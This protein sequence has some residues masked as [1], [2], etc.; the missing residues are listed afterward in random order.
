MMSELI[1]QHAL[2]VP[3]GLTVAFLLAGF[4]LLVLS[5]DLD[6]K[7]RYAVLALAVGVFV[8]LCV[9]FY[10]FTVDDAYISL[11]Y[12]RNLANGYGLVFS[13]DGSRP[14][15]GYTNFLWVLLETPLYLLRLSDSLIL[16]CIKIAGIA[17]GV[18]VILLTYRMTRLF[19]QDNRAGLFA[20][21][22]LAAV[23]QLSFWAIGGLETT[24]YMFWLLA[25]VY[26][27][28]VEERDNRVHILSMLF[29]TLA[30]LTRWEGVLVVLALILWE[31]ATHVWNRHKGDRL[32]GLG[33]LIP[34]IIVF[35][36]IYG[37]YFL[38][39][40]NFYGYLFPNTVYAR[41][42][43]SGVSQIWHRMNEMRPFIVYLL[44]I[45]ALAWFGYFYLAKQPK[46]TSQQKQLLGVV[47]L[48]L[49]ALSFGS[50]REW[51]PGFRYELP[52]V[53][54]LILFFSVAMW[55]IVG[56]QNKGTFVISFQSGI[57]RLG[58]LLCLGI[59]LLYPAIDLHQNTKYTD[60]LDRAHATL[61]KWLREYAPTDASYASWD[62]G[63]VPYYSELPLIIEI[64]PEGI[65]S[66][67]ITH[68]GY[69]VNYFLSLKPSFIVLPPQ[70]DVVTDQSG[71]GFYANGYFR[72][73]YELIFSFALRK[74]YIL[75]V[76]KH[77]DVYISQAALE[78]GRQL[79]DLSWQEA[80][81][82]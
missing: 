62:M 70:P 28:M 41:G 51:M 60:E 5:R 40:Y 38:W 23:P 27:Y 52:W 3:L 10:K 71:F 19:T 81:A 7:R 73:N 65:L 31:A 2:V 9:S 18:G 15:E 63:A 48:V 33:K 6:R 30:A 1:Q 58:L 26:F 11:R 37:A 16:H 42:G 47:F 80:Q 17:F 64:H 79:A 53:P 45:V 4:G 8:A 69:D 29:L 36:L 32:R 61:G 39:R 72:D 68:V 74:D 49:V 57:A 76:Y 54:I 59:F 35:A 43:V 50:K 46:D 25:G 44:P 12:A 66:T 14:V 55:K 34:G 56:D 20:C 24:M 78:E 13:T 21:L 77:K 22:F 67:Y 75:A 82:D